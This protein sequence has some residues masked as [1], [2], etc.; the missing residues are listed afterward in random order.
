MIK[1]GEGAVLIGTR[2]E[3]GGVARGIGASQGGSIGVKRPW[4]HLR[5]LNC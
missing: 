2:G 4:F 5:R 3:T 1:L